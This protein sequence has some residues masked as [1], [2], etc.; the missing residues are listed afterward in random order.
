MFPFYVSCSRGI[1]SLLFQEVGDLGATNLKETVGGVSGE[2]SLET[3]YRINL[4][5]RLGSKVTLVLLSAPVTTQETL[6]THVSTIDWDDHMSPNSTFKINFD[7]RLKDID[8]ENYGALIVKDAIVDQFRDRYAAR[9]DVERDR[10][11]VVVD[12]KVRKSQVTIALDISGEPLGKRGYRQALSKAPLRENLAAALLIRAGW[13]EI[14]KNNGALIDPMCG[15]GTFLVEAAWMAADWAPGMGRTYFGFLGWKQHDN[16]LWK[17]LIEEA[18]IRRGEGLNNLPP[19]LGYDASSKAVRNAESNIHRAGLDANIKVYVK[20]LATWKKPTHIALEKGLLIT[21]PPYGERLGDVV[22]LKGL[23]RYLGEV[24]KSDL[25]GWT[26]GIFT[27]NPDLGKSMAIHSKKQYRL[28]NGSIDCKLLMFDIQESNFVNVPTRAEGRLQDL[29]V[30]PEGPRS[31]AN[32]IRKNEKRLSKWV[33]KEQVQAYRIYDAD[34]PEYSIA[35]DRYGDWLHVAEY[36]APK[37]IPEEKTRKRFAEAIEALTPATGVP[38]E[39]I[40]FKE[41]SRQKGKEQYEKLS[42]GQDSLVIEEAGVQVEVNL[43]DYLDTGLFL[44]HRPIRQKIQ[45]LSKGKKFLN[46]FCYTGVATLHAA[47][48]GARSTFS[49]DMSNTYISWL[50]RNLELNG[51]SDNKHQTEVAD[52]FSWLKSNKEKFDLIFLDPPTFS[53]SK[54]MRDTLDIQRDHGGLIEMSM[55]A[56]APQ[57]LL[58]FSNNRRGFSLDQSVLDAYSVKDITKESIPMDFDRN[59]KIHQCWEIRSK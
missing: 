24:L 52:C 46:L 39:N 33:K 57:G 26:A 53:N 56:L 47:R 1:E 48:G 44:D 6:L 36:L 35:V 51:F 38:M 49:V 11:D 29:T 55:D 28:L 4:W 42:S 20:E 22:A 40:V 3:L 19:I 43:T 31:V 32:R 25:N 45:G 27:G 15:S 50:R 13:P 2:A 34:I 16:K 41:R 21:N 5:S 23:Y 37:N 30:L 9:P 10:P 18:R 8:N 14:A 12:I 7:G 54:K 58:I 17:D 59:A